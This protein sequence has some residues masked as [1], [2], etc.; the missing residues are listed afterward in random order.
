V[1][2][3]SVLLEQFTEFVAELVAEDFAERLDGQEETPRRI[4]PSATIGGKASSGN[5]VVDMGMMRRFLKLCGD[6]RCLTAD[7]ERNANLPQ[8]WII[9]KIGS[10]GPPSLQSL[11]ISC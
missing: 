10:V 1:E 7:E 4:D 2:L 6:E 11:T 5:D 3:K 8:S 9:G